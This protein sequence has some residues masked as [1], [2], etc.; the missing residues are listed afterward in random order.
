MGVAAYWQ[1]DYQTAISE[2]LKGSPLDQYNRYY[3][4]LSYEKSGRGEEA[5]ALF[6]EI[7]KFNRNS[8]FYAFV[9]PAAVAKL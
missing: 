1:K 6:S 3:L 5:K 7:A 4:A 9:R 2:L 8:L